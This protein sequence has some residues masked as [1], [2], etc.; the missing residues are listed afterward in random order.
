MKRLMTAAAVIVFTVAMSV[1]AV[2][3]SA[4][5]KV[6]P[7]PWK[8]MP[9]AATDIGVGGGQ[10]WVLGRK[11]MNYGFPVFRWNG[12]SWD[13]MKGQAVRIDVG[14]KGLAW[15]VNSKQDIFRHDGSRWIK[16]PGK[17]HDIGVG[18]N[19][20]VWVIGTNKEGGGYGIYR[21]RKDRWEKMPGSAVRIDVGPRGL[22]WVV[23]NKRDIFRFDG[24]KWVRVPGKARDIGVGGTTKAASVWIADT[25]RDKNGGHVR[26]WDGKRWVRFAGQ[27]VN[28]SADSKGA[29]FGTTNAGGV[30][31]HARAA[32]WTPKPL[33]N[34]KAEKITM[35]QGRL[36]R[37]K[38]AMS[39]NRKQ[40]TDMQAKLK[41][42]N[43]SYG[44]M[45]GQLAAATKALAGLK[46]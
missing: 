8:K 38:K 19:G 28:V 33:A 27:I 13:N 35:W 46:K 39:D 18:A 41:T 44:K 40:A 29:P 14:P 37:V 43:T 17:A 10:V 7:L 42:L 26:R 1:G 4:Q 32:A 20:V 31:A 3:V 22:A 25:A 6:N 12:K 11:K 36:D 15:V 34:P 9:G 23:N 21:L 2:D 16:M 5:E 24:K 45:K 30:W